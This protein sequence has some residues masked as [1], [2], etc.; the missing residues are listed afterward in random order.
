MSKGEN[1]KDELTAKVKELGATVAFDAVAGD[2]TGDLLDCLPKKGTVYV[3]GGLAGVAAVAALFATY[4][5][6]VRN[7]EAAASLQG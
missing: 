6:V 2:M 5:L 1:W 4:S 3:Y 7:R